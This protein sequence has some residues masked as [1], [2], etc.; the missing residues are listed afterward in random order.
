MGGDDSATQQEV[1]GAKQVE[2]EVGGVTD[3]DTPTGQ[4][5]PANEVGVVKDSSSPTIT[6]DNQQRDDGLVSMATPPQDS[7]QTPQLSK[8]PRTD[9][10]P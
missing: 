9:E 7:E 5:A 2:G 6:E 1:G 3:K 4:G 10:E 8:R